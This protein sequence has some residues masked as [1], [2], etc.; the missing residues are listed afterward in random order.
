MQVLEGTSRSSCC[1]KKRVSLGNFLQ[2]VLP[3]GILLELSPWT[4]FFL[5]KH[6][7][8]YLF[9]N[10]SQGYSSSFP[11]IWAYREQAQEDFSSAS[12]AE[13]SKADTQR[14][15]AKVKG[16]HCSALAVSMLREESGKMHGYLEEREDQGAISKA[17]PWAPSVHQHWTKRLCK[18]RTGCDLYYIHP[19]QTRLHHLWG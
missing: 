19:V 2:P 1:Q 3:I 18:R 14:G 7:L 5:E 6:G 15:N 8:V 9:Q 17:W 13:V 12:R 4:F 11:V 10:G 16:R